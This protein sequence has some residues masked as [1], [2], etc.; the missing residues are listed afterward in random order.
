MRFK[1]KIRNAIIYL[2]FIA[3][4]QLQQHDLVDSKKFG[5]YVIELHMSDH[6]FV[7]TLHNYIID[8]EAK[9][10]KGGTISNLDELL[11]KSALNKMNSLKTKRNAMQAKPDYWYS[12]QGR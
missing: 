10:A 4:L 5:D 12:R 9:L 7:K 6:E 3:L 2:L 8:L 11:L 1:L